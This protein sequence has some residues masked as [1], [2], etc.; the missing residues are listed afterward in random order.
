[1]E[2]SYQAEARRDQTVT[3]GWLKRSAGL[4]LSGRKK[5]ARLPERL[6]QAEQVG[7]QAHR[8]RLDELQAEYNA[9]KAHRSQAGSG[10]RGESVPR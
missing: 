4:L 1:M 5:L 9:L 6:Q 7:R 2:A 8:E 10:Q 3:A